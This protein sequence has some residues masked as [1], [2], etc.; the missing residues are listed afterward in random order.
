V[1]P[2]DGGRRAPITHRRRSVTFGYVAIQISQY[3]GAASAD[4]RAFEHCRNGMKI[5]AH[6]VHQAVL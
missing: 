1:A 3:L 6:F 4:A 2:G 5:A